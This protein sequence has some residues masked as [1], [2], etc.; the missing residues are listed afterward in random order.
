[1]REKMS[2]P[3]SSK[4][5]HC[6]DSST[7][8]VFA[9]PVVAASVFVAFLAIQFPGQFPSPVELKQEQ[10]WSRSLYTQYERLQGD[11]ERRSLDCCAE[12]GLRTQRW[13]LLGHEEIGTKRWSWTHCLVHKRIETLHFAMFSQMTFWRESAWHWSCCFRS[14]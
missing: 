12:R 1:M 9:A 13:P 8:T 5:W 6:V 2:L 11:R 3:V 7:A 10:E 4:Q 14:E